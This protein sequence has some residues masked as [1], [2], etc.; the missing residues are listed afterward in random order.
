[1][2]RTRRIARGAARALGWTVLVLGVAVASIVATLETHGGRAWLAERLESSFNDALHG[3]LRIGEIRSARGLTIHATDVVFES[4]EGDPILRIEEATT[5]LVLRA[6]LAGELQLH[7]T[8]ADGVRVTISPGSEEST[9]LVETF[10]SRTRERGTSPLAIDTHTMHVQNA[11][12]VVAMGG[13]EIRITSIRGFVR[14]MRPAHQRAS[15]RLDRIEGRFEEG[16]GS[17]VLGSP[18]FHAQGVIRAG[19]AV[20]I[21]LQGSLCLDPA[22]D[23]SVDLRNDVATLRLDEDHRALG[24]ALRVAGAFISGLVVERVDGVEDAPSGC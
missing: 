4:P 1:M 21:D 2:T 24:A 15:V 3:R 20:R 22:L 8:R 12:L 18:A 13:P 14:V 17:R 11:T 9:S 6:L 7:D 23:F 16:P 5:G 19:D 10:S